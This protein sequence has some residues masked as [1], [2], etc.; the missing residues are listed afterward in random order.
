MAFSTSSPILLSLI[1]VQQG[2]HFL[3]FWGEVHSSLWALQPDN[4]LLQW[5]SRVETHS[6]MVLC[7]EVQ[8]GSQVTGV[9]KYLHPQPLQRSFT[10]R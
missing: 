8:G 5:H 4:S 10:Y 1:P 2:C 9:A 7:L 6:V 3:C